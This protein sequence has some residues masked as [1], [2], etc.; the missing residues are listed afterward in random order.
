MPHGNIN[1]SLPHG[2]NRFFFH[3]LT[4]ISIFLSLHGD[5]QF[6]FLGLIVACLLCLS[7][8]EL[9]GFCRIFLRPDCRLLAMFDL[10]QAERPLHDIPSALRS[11]PLL[12]ILIYHSP[13]GDNHFFLP[14]TR[15]F[16]PHGDV[17]FFF[18]SR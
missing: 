11:R 10:L 16:A 15:G 13:H 5:Y 9:N 2:G 17:N 7:S 3:L 12:A 4:A 18:A 1:F 6:F 14:F 8:F